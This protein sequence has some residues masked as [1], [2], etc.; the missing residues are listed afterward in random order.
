MSCFA[1][2][3]SKAEKGTSMYST[4]IT[5]H[6][7]FKTNLCKY[8][9]LLGKCFVCCEVLSQAVVNMRS[10]IQQ[11]VVAYISD[12]QS[13]GYTDNPHWTQMLLRIPDIIREWWFPTAPLTKKGWHFIDPPSRGVQIILVPPPPSRGLNCYFV[14]TLN[15]PTR[16][17][18]K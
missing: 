15:P 18:I 16:P 14:P 9:F 3:F 6:S 11:W 5:W 10:G 1:Q 4:V 7:I 13:N 2:R 12:K 8:D 17:V